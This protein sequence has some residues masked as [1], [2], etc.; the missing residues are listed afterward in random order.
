MKIR[1]R[2]ILKI[3][4]GAAA[5]SVLPS[6]TSSGVPRMADA[7]KFARSLSA[8]YKNHGLHPRCVT[9]LDFDWR[10]YAEPAYTL[11]DTRPI[12]NWHWK[13]GSPAD[14]D[15]MTAMNVDVHGTGWHKAN[16][17]FEGMPVGYAWYRAEL[18]VM[19]HTG[20]VIAFTH[21]DD[22][23]RVYLNGHYLRAHRGWNRPFHIHLD[24][25]WNARGSNIITLL[26]HNAAGP[27]G[28]YGPVNAGYSWQTQSNAAAVYAI[29]YNDSSWR[30]VQLPHDYIVEGEY[31][32]AANRG[33]GSLPVNPAWYRKTFHI[34]AHDS[35]RCLWL[36]FEGIYRDAKIYLNGQLVAEH[37][38]GY[39]SLHVDISNHARCGEDNLLAIYV[40]PTHFEGWWYEGG[41]IYRHVWLN[42]AD[43]VHVA[44]WGVYVT[45]TVENVTGQPSAQLCIETTVAN[46]TNRGAS[47]EVVSKIYDPQGRLV[48]A[49]QNS[50][51]VPPTVKSPKV[52]ATVDTPDNA[53][54]DQPSDLHLGTK[55][56]QTVQIAAAQ[57][58]SLEHPRRYHVET[59]V[60]VNGRVVDRH[61]QKFGIRTLR[62]D[63]DAGFFLNEQP[64]KIQG[65]CNHQDFA[66]V[67]I[68]LP[69][70]ILFYRM[71]KLKEFGCNA[72]RCSHN[73]MAPAMYDACD[74]L[75]LLVMDEN[76]HPGSTIA[77]KA[78]VGQPYH[79][80]WHVESMVLRDRNHPSVFMW[81][82]WNEE[83]AIQSDAYGREMM[84]YLLKVVHRHDITRPVTCADNH[85][86]GKRG[87]LQGVGA[88]ENLLGVNYNYGDYDWLHHAYPDKMIFGSEIGSNLECRGI[89]HTN[90]KAAHLT[91]YMT[92]EGS[93]HPLATR[94]FV[95]GGFYWTGFD[96]RGETTPF[97][98]PEINSNFGFLDMCG[99]PK[100]GAYYWK[101][102]WMPNTPVLHIFP[103]WNWPDH[104][105][106]NIPV[107]CFSNCQQVEL[108]LNGKS[109]GRKHMPAFRH[110]Q[111][112]HVRYAPGRL[113]ARGYNGGHL[114]ATTVVETTGPAATIGIKPD[115]HG[116]VADGQD[117]VPIAISILDSQGRVVP[118]ADNKVHFAI[119][120]P[121]VISGVGNGDPSC[122]EPN[123]ADYRSAF[124][125]YCMVLVRADRRGGRISLTASSPGLKSARVVLH[126]V[127]ID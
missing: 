57:L 55:L 84:A 45:S 6:C 22:N 8:E 107:W 16:T 127:S 63:P 126:S 101:S 36:Y 10:F 119:S 122:H 14:A 41:G 112:N 59:E 95:A 65:T 117:T 88:S 90:K 60:I 13:M 42:S 23:A 9:L 73:N 124:N 77:T 105:G 11:R 116:L 68:G 78:W 56:F 47:C 89:Y 29:D 111:W 121:G 53:D 25:Y 58:W 114:V 79:N 1:R 2:D 87:W 46:R 3:T 50:L 115:R 82:M 7:E 102:W 120:G 4:T 98:W 39:T 51:T 19:P 104:E 97:G 70:S 35:G 21:V 17:R 76:R 67:G 94:L 49:A 106:S 15:A 28:I 100:D 30:K 72:I 113:E 12:N 92:P 96:Y 85:G 48:G 62:F 38:G 123:Q 43:P 81:S 26:V 66:G 75:G 118:T 91:S 86:L 64:V 24:K 18:P 40:D 110:L 33:H 52:N 31:S 5:L 80:T 69:D 37:P 27:G 32:R 83:W 99:F 71:Q 103:H 109:L 34:P 54:I 108:I 93:W 74:E 61:K 44:P 20:R 125:G